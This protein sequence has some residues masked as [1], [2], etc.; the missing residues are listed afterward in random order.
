MKIE[1]IMKK[2]KNILEIKVRT[3]ISCL[4]ISIYTEWLDI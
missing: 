2:K 3:F 1:E 4:K